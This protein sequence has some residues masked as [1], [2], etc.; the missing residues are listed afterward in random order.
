M[1]SNLHRP[2]TVKEIIHFSVGK[3]ALGLILVAQSNQGICAIALGDN[4]ES[5]I[6]A[7]Q[8]RFSKLDIIADDNKLKN[9][10]SHIANWIDKPVAD[11]EFALDL[12]GTPFQQQVWRALRNIPLG[13]TATYT[14]IANQ[15]NMPKAAR[16]VA[17][18]CAANPVALAIPCHRVVRQDG[19]L[20]GY[21]WG[22]ERKKALLKK[23]I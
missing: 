8:T 13:K 2:A 11:L 15:I 12:R 20:S 14:D 23:E 6:D 19:N 3:S 5:L 7:L 16:A 10:I 22:I 18:A 17:L 1:S 4:A 9:V 21:R